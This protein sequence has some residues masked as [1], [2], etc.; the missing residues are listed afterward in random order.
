MTVRFAILAGVSTDAQATPEKLSIPDQLKHCRE[1]I[2][3][4]NGIE[5]TEP[6]IMDGY[7]RTGYDSLEVAMREI[8]PLAAAIHAAEADQYDV[9]LMDNFDRL[10][11]LGFNV[12]TR[13][14]KL[15]K[16]LYS[17]RQSGKLADPS[18]YDPY[19]NET[20][21]IAMYVEGIIQSY[22]INKIRRGWNIG[23]PE[24]ARKGLHPLSVPFGY[25]L[26]G[27]DQPVQAVDEEQRLIRQ[28][29]GSYLKGATLQSIADA[30]NASGI[31]PRRASFWKLPVIKKIITNQF[32][33]GVTTFGKMRTLNGKRIPV[34]Q[35]EWVSGKGQHVPIFDEATYL[36]ILNETERRD[37]LRS[38]SQTYAL[39]GLLTCSICGGRLHR[40]GKL[41]TRYPVDL[42]CL[43]VPSCVNIYYDVALKIVAKEVTKQ[44]THVIPP[45]SAEN[46]PAA[47]LTRISKLEELRREIQA[48]YKAK[49][50]TIAEASREIASIETEI[51]R[52]QRQSERAAQH[53]QRRQTLLAL[54]QQDLS[55]LQ[56]WII[57]DDPTTVNHLL[58]ALC[59]TIQIT[60]RY[61]LTI[62]WR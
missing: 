12:K 28:M 60:P 58:T 49:I 46:T 59:Q 24:R 14:K 38:R 23:V 51:A 5:T 47:F 9:L 48:G 56:D 15:R 30:A 31:P 29:V 18:A 10:G 3:A 22:R 13:F 2:A 4:L 27:K 7:S 36:A 62:I 42:S 61:E 11:D 50:Y 53:V 43:T 25:K 37:G 20:D 54:A 16:Q 34:P 44:L 1:K 33:A 39:T 8:P 45:E 57:H 19:A 40:H 21:D 32:Y 41:G 52:L 26:V 35:S 55:I 6:F 17:A